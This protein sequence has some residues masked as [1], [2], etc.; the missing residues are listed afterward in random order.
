MYTQ[1]DT[2]YI[3]LYKALVAT[4][5]R[6]RTLVEELPPLVALTLIRDL[7]ATVVQLMVA[8]RGAGATLH[9]IGAAAGVSRQAVWNR[10]NEQG[11]AE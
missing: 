11:R 3:W 9:E 8:A 6:I 4:P 10:L 1:I 7:S 5:Q 2:A